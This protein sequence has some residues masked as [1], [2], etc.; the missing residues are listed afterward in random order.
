[1]NNKNRYTVEEL[2]TIKKLYTVDNLSVE[3][4]SKV[5]SRTPSAIENICYSSGWRKT[6]EQILDRTSLDLSIL[7][8]NNPF[9]YYFAGWAMTDGY[10]TDKHISFNLKDREVLDIFASHFGLDKSSVKQVNPNLFSLGLHSKS[11]S[12]FICQSFS[13]TKVSKT[14]DLRLDSNLALSHYFPLLLRGIVEGDGCIGVYQ[15]N[16]K[17]SYSGIQITSASELFLLDIQNILLTIDISSSIRTRKVKQ[18]SGYISTAYDLTIPS[19]D[20]VSFI[21]YIY[22]DYDNLRMTRK[23][24]KATHLLKF[25][26]TIKVK[27]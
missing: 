5:T 7:N 19:R 9:V 15:K 24:N 12:D 18:R 3:E 8:L 22:S 17:D 26:N 21:N 6:K 10:I 25:R 13:I 11:M 4:I 27:I 1:M 14:F 2:D 23:H 16:G 20:Q